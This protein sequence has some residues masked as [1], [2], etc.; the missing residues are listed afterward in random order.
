MA[1][2]D[3][4]VRYPD[5]FAEAVQHE[6]LEAEIT[7]KTVESTMVRHHYGPWDQR[8]YQILAYLEGRGLISAQQNE[9]QFQ[10]SLTTE[11]KIVADVFKKNVAYNELCLQMKEVKKVFGHRSGNSLKNLI[12][13]TFKEEIVERSLGETIL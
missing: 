3:F 4:F 11:G 5:F 6:G 7:S 9:N 13:R 1:K 10:L 8:Y 2:L 12:Y